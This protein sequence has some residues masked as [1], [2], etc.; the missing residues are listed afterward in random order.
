MRSMDNVAVRDP[1]LDPELHGD[2]RQGR[3][4]DGGYPWARKRAF[5]AMSNETFPAAR[6]AMAA[7]MRR[8]IFPRMGRQW[9]LAMRRAGFPGEGAGSFQRDKQGMAAHRPRRLTISTRRVSPAGANDSRKGAG[10]ACASARAGRR[11]RT[12]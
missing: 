11:Q 9:R 3:A 7:G 12:R 4:R 8:W 6:Q 1:V 5:P 10:E 2:P